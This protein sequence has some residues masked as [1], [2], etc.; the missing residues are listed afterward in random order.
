MI[1]SRYLYFI[2]DSILLNENIFNNGK[3]KKDLY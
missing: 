3:F 2:D 1:D